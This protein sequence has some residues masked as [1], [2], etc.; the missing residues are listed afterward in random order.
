MSR[1][2]GGMRKR[3][4]HK[5]I[6]KLAKGY[7]GNKSKLSGLPTRRVM[8]SLCMLIET[9]RPGR[10]T[11]ETLDNQDQRCCQDER[12]QLHANS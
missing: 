12:H 10:E 1:V 5:K 3:A 6:L 8:K 7:F 4:R 9:G 11:Q 2:K